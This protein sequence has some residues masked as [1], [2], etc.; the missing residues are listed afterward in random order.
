[1][2]QRLRLKADREYSRFRRLCAQL[3]YSI[4]RQHPAVQ[5]KDL[6]WHHI[7]QSPVE[8][9]L[10]WATQPLRSYMLT[11]AS[12]TKFEPQNLQDHYPVCIDFFLFY[13][14]KKGPTAHYYM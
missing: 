9:S 6:V 12:W 4:L 14:S 7:L 11:K 1:M 13:K 2:Q 3:F 5:L 8:F 10:E